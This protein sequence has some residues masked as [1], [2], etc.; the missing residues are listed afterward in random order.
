MRYEACLGPGFAALAK[1]GEES[2]G[3]K[4]AVVDASA[5]A[6]VLNS[7]QQ[8]GHKSGQLLASLEAGFYRLYLG[9]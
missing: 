5:V 2:V 7:I 3:V 4:A 1:G 8:R 9:L 6:P